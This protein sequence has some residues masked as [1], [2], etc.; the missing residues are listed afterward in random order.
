MHN[1]KVNTKYRHQENFKQNRTINKNIYKYLQKNKEECAVKN[2]KTNPI[3]AQNNIG[4]L[5]YESGDYTTDPKGISKMPNKQFKL[6]F[7]NAKSN[8]RI[9]NAHT[10]FE[11]EGLHKNKICKN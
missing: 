4:Q 6:V 3:H 1:A 10:F 2:V 7:T 9:E 8:K 5:K 11:A